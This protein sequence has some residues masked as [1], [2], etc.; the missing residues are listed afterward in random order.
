MDSIKA[1]WHLF[2]VH[3]H[4]IFK[5]WGARLQSL[6]AEM[7]VAPQTARWLCQFSPGPTQAWGEYTLEGWSFGIA[8]THKGCW[9]GRKAAQALTA[10]R[11]GGMLTY[12]LALPPVEGGFCTGRA[13][14]WDFTIR[15]DY[16]SQ[17]SL[18][19]W[20]GA[21][22]DNWYIP[23]HCICCHWGFA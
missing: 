18:L 23:S 19:F 2:S 17:S 12:C 11:R 20:K 1:L 10:S 15:V 9:K 22:S 7:L 14:H 4:S 8:D 6:C 3:P 13:V 5:C 16:W 21:V